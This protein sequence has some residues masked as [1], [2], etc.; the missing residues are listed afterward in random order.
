L[1][2]CS[3]QNRA[4]F[5]LP[6]S[7]ADAERDDR[8]ARAA[9]ASNTAPTV[10]RRVPAQTREPSFRPPATDERGLASGFLDRRVPAR[11]SSGTRIVP[12]SALR[13]YG[14]R[15]TVTLFQRLRDFLL[16]LKNPPQSRREGKRAA[17]TL[18]RRP[19]VQPHFAGFHVDLPP[20]EREDFARGAP[21]GDIRELDDRPHVD[22][23]LLLH[24]R[25]L[26]RLE[27]PFP[28][29]VLLQE[30]NVRACHELP[31]LHRQRAHPLQEDQLAVDRRVRRASRLTSG[32]C[33]RARPR[34]RWRRGVGARS[35]A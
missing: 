18:F 32:P 8:C 33:R 34:W 28:D 6:G 14:V 23:K 10:S 35:T 1:R 9:A 2:Y 7:A 25:E 5:P 27:K 19:G 13:K 16:I 22:G 12:T 26:L 30:R 21:T 11:D 20:L 24:A 3:R 31:R 29:I 15:R 17:L 4:P